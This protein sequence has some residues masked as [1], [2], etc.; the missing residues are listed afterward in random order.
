MAN[1][2]IDSLAR[3]RL[4]AGANAIVVSVLSVVAIFAIAG[5]LLAQFWDSLD[6]IRMPKLVGIALGWF[7][8]TATTLGIAFFL[9]WANDR[10]DVDRSRRAIRLNFDHAL[11]AML[12]LARNF[13]TSTDRNLIG[14]SIELAQKQIIASS[15]RLKR[16]ENKLTA[17]PPA[18]LNAYADLENEIDV[19]LDELNDLHRRARVERESRFPKF[20]FEV[21]DR[22]ARFEEHLTLIHV[23]ATDASRRVRE[24]AASSQN[25]M[26]DSQKSAIDPATTAQ[27]VV[28]R[29]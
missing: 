3:M 17:F 21:L 28:R 12:D 6:H 20:G 11:I 14:A 7:I 13:S 4:L 2:T 19:A 15:A 18:S 5:V 10:R 8:A 26:D 22:I 25:P 1:P 9:M 16:F 29:A 23:H 27:V 24:F